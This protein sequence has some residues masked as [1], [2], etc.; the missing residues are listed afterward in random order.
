[1]SEDTGNECIM[2]PVPWIEWAARMAT[3]C[4]G[5][6]VALE[7]RDEAHAL[8]PAPTIHGEQQYLSPH[9]ES[10]VDIVRVEKNTVLQ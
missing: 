1:M 4:T 8:V 2:I 6:P 10:V 7:A 5:F 3:F 9:L